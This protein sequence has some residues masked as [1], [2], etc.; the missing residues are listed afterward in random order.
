M[1][2]TTIIKKAIFILLLLSIFVIYKSFGFERRVASD[3][4]TTEQFDLAKEL[5]QDAEKYRGYPGK[6]FVYSMQVIDTL[7]SVVRSTTELDVYINSYEEEKRDSLIYTKTGNSAGNIILQKGI[8]MWFYKPGTANAFRISPAQRLLG[9][10]SY[11]DVSST[12]YSLFYDPIEMEETAV[13]ETDAY[14]VKLKKV[15]NG[16]AYDTIDFYLT[17]KE[18]KPIKAEFFTP[19]GKKLKI[20]YFR[21]FG[22]LNNKVIAREWVIVDAIN[23]KAIT[24]IKIQK[25]ALSSLSDKTFTVEGVKNF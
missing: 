21:D 6:D 23:E 9:G 25:I 8:N 3:K 7:A 19:S 17:K 16:A 15:E 13:G 14:K 4:L 1:N 12:N 11:A 5:V 24:F 10:A 20:M 2:T 18:A 22:A